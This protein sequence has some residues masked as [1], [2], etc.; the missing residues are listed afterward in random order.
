MKLTYAKILLVVAASQMVFLADAATGKD[1]SA[2]AKANAVEIK[3]PVVRDHTGSGPPPNPI[4]PQKPQH[5]CGHYG[6]PSCF[7]GKG[8]VRDHRTNP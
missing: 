3:G 2:A 8:T 7:A 1:L 5:Q 4:P 6:Q